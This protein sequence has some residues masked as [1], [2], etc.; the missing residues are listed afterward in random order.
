MNKFLVFSCAVIRPE[1]D[2]PQVSQR[3][4]SRILAVSERVNKPL[5][6]KKFND[7]NVLH[8]KDLFG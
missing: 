3:F 6:N 5:I 1:M 2:L 8:E 7:I 4:Y